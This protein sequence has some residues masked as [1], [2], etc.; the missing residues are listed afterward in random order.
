MDLDLETFQRQFELHRSFAN[1]DAYYQTL[2]ALGETT[3]AIKER[4]EIAYHSRNG[5]VLETAYLPRPTD[6]QI[7]EFARHLAGA[8]S[9]YKH[10]S[11]EGTP[12][13]LF[14]NPHVMMV[15]SFDADEP[16]ENKSSDGWTYGLVKDSQ[17][18]NERWGHWKL[19]NSD[20]CF[21]Y[22]SFPTT[23]YRELFGH[24]DYRL[25][26]DQVRIE[27][28]AT[29]Q[30]LKL[31]PELLF[32]TPLTRDVWGSYIKNT[33]DP[34]SKA[35]EIPVEK[36][37]PRDQREIDRCQNRRQQLEALSTTIKEFLAKLD[38]TLHNSVFEKRSQMNKE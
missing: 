23:E 26:G 32:S 10:L 28:Q 36:R 12:F 6:K 35:T 19:A 3:R 31:P 20:N 2:L 16:D 11:K 9:W 21:H 15:R 29:S 22:S 1:F 7:E 17:L 38:S 27:L 5:Y 37:T 8:H 25:T 34:M 18:E 33:P 13:Y 24:L 4:G 30:P 14:L